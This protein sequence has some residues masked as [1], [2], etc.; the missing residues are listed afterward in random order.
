MCV[1]EVGKGCPGLVKLPKLG[2]VTLGTDGKMRTCTLEF[3]WRD[4]GLTV[5]WQWEVPVGTEGRR[6]G[7]V[8]PCPTSA[9]CR[10]TA[11]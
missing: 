2:F 4:L 8:G 3:L 7:V 10:V 6:S 9:A 11:C 5:K 1:R